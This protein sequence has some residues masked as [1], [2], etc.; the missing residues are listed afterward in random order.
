MNSAIAFKSHNVY[1]ATYDIHWGFVLL[2]PPPAGELC[3]PKT[4]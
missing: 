2:Y 1:F 4:V 3:W